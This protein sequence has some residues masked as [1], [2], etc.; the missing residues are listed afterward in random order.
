MKNLAIILSSFFIPFLAHATTWEDPYFEEAVEEA[1]LI[2]IGA[3][4]AS[5]PEKTTIQT[6]QI[7]KGKHKAGEHVTILKTAIQGHHHKGDTLTEGDQFFFIVKKHKKNYIAFTDTYWRF[8]LNDSLISVPIRDPLAPVSVNRDDFE[9]FLTLLIDKNSAEEA[10]SFVD[11]Q[12]KKLATLNPITKQM[13]EIEKQMFILEV[14]YHFGK[15]THASYIV[16]Y[17]NSPYYHI[18]WSCVRALSTCGGIKSKRAILKHIENEEIAHV[19][20]ALG[21]AIFQLNI[22]EAKAPLKEKIPRVS[23]ESV[24]LSSNIMNPVFNTLPSPRS[25]YGAALMKINGIKGSYVDLLSQSGKYIANNPNI[26][27]DI[28]E[29]K[30]TYYSI[31]K[32]MRHPDSVY[33]LVL[34]REEL[35]ELPA[36]IKSFKNLKSLSI[37]RNKIKQLPDYLPELGLIKLDLSNNELTSVPDVLYNCT[38]LKKLNLKSNKLTAI[39]PR[40]FNLKEL[41]ELNLNSN[42]ISEIPNEI[43]KLM[44]LKKLFLRMNE[45]ESLPNSVA[46]LKKL[47]EIELYGN[48]FYKFPETLSA[49]NSIKTILMGS[50]SIKHLPESVVDMEKLKYIDL[51]Y[52][53]LS[54]KERDHISDFPARIIVNTKSYEDRFYSIHEAV[55]HKDISTYIHDNHNDYSN[56]ELDLS[57]LQSTISLVLTHNKLKKFP[58]GV[59]ALNNLKTLI[60]RHNNISKV[61]EDI[62]KMTSL[63]RLDLS[64]N[65][66]TSLPSTV[67]ELPLKYLYLGNNNFNDPEKALIKSWFDEDCQIF[68]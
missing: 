1:G 31:D 20:S 38:T 15:A 66:L 67:G 45:L 16:Q 6:T 13:H 65:N 61:P 35:S 24:P 53:S 43:G 34:E 22:S 59:T 60:L 7:F 33:I 50:N 3:V 57:V 56:L 46:N 42:S 64:Y 18:R 49:S 27:L 12:I 44:N 4:E 21:K 25:S 47:E 10:Q 55:E 14:L 52:N 29:T 23:Y 51:S 26:A 58:P 48:D 5:S 19:Q 11:H 32:A 39:D 41:E 9:T 63:N 2:C 36:E 40:L 30:K 62:N 17:L 8:P 37:Y 54:L 28:L 68:W